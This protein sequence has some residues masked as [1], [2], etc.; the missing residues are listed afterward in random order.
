[1]QS[2]VNN[3]IVF[4]VEGL[5]TNCPQVWALPHVHCVMLQE[6]RFI[7]EAVSTLRTMEW[8]L[9]QVRK[10]MVHVIRFIIENSSTYIALILCLS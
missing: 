10:T 3:E 2:L 1:M 8:H 5:S 7:L 4:G 6:E 9:I